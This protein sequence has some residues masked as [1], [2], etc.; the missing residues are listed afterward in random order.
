MNDA[1]IIRL[2]H[3]KKSFGALTVLKDLTISVAPHETLVVLGPSG[4]GKSVLLKHIVGLLRPDA[5]EVY[6]HNQRVDLMD[7]AQLDSVRMHMG[8]LF[9]QG[10]LFDSLNVG[11]NIAFPLRE[12]GKKSE[13]EINHI[14]RNRLSMVGLEDTM[15]KMPAELSGG[16]RKRVALARAIALEPEVVLYD[17]P[18]TGL[19]PIRSDIISELILKLKE[20]LNVTSVVVTHDM[21]NAFK[22]ADRIVLLWDGC[23]IAEGTPDQIRQH[24]DPR[25]QRFVEGRA[26]A[27]ELKALNRTAADGASEDDE[28]GLQP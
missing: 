17:E 24:K 15:E 19:D 10:A 21:A 27:K 13:E 14:V 6:F 2:V 3:V 11:D 26:S 22:V 8:F 5:G 28:T 20:E 12:S 4:T 1:P 23:V 25:V 18:T 9:Q 7:E 16:Q